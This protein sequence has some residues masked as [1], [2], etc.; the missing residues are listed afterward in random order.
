MADALRNSGR[1][2]V[3]S[4]SNN[5]NP[6]NAPSVTPLA[7]SWRTTGDIKANWKSMSDRGFGQDKWRQYSKPGHWNDPDMLEI[8]TKEKNQPGLTPNEEYT[9][10]T[11]WCLVESPLL[12]ANDM[13]DMD[14]FTKNL[15]ENDEVISVSQDSLGDQAVQVAQDGDARVYAK[16]ME[17]GSKAVGLFNTGTNGAITVTVKWEDLGIHG[18][19]MVRD[20]W[21]QK[22]LGKSDKEFSMKVEPHSAELVKISP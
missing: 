9:H 4:L 6:Q 12:L 22:D 18:S 20:L 16:K 5:L 11:L 15:L 7:N 21:R 10:M 17:D 3:F 1:D 14:A 2:I 13:S 8:A 19:Q